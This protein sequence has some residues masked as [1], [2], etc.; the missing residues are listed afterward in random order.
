MITSSRMKDLNSGEGETRNLEEALAIDFSLLMSTVIPDIS[1]ANVK[2][3]RKESGGIVQRMKSAGEILFENVADE[4]L[5]QFVSHPSDTVRGWLCFALMKRA[6][7]SVKQRLTRITA[8]AD[9]AHFGVR[10]WAWMAWRP[11]LTAELETGLKALKPW[12]VNKSPRL[13]RFVTESSRPRGV[14]C[15]HIKALKENPGLAVDLLEPL[16]SDPEKYVQDSVANWLN[17]ASKSQ[18]DWVKALTDRWILESSTPET[19]RI[20]HRSLRALRKASP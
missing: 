6:D 17:D 15:A 7:L 20:V 5:T 19:K 16:K 1:V 3:L 18:P 12:T 8:L 9:D 2:C 14:W 10:E 11:F 13:R 4:N